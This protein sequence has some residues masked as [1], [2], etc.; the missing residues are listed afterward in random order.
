ALMSAVPVANPDF[1]TERIVLEG[2]VP[3]PVD[4]PSGCYFH[5]R[6]P[7]SEPNCS[8]REPE[9]REIE[10]DHYVHCHY[11]EDLELGGLASME[12]E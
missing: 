2:D 3:S 1:E 8:E 6:C 5:P 4:P 12:S 11:A 9:F 10:D 7:Y